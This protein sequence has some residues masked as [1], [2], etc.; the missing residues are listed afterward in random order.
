[1]PEPRD[2]LHSGRPSQPPPVEF[3]HPAA[4]ISA[5]TG[6]VTTTDARYV[7]DTSLTAAG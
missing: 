2:R 4:A 6:E 1:M 5:V 3:H 7:T